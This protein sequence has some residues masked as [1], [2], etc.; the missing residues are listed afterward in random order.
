MNEKIRDDV[1]ED[2][3]RAGVPMVRT[4]ACQAWS[5]HRCACALDELFDAGA[6]VLVLA[7]TQAAT[8]GEFLE[9]LQHELPAALRRIVL[10]TVGGQEAQP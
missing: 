4:A 7:A 6:H 5:A 2:R 1:F 9:R 10:A 3:L 8:D